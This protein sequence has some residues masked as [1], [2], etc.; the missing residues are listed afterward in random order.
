MIDP[1]ESDLIVPWQKGGVF[2]K[3]VRAPPNSGNADVLENPAV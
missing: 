2:E 3:H 1:E